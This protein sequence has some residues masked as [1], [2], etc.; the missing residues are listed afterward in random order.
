[1]RTFAADLFLG[2]YHHLICFFSCSHSSL[3]PASPY[4]ESPRLPRDFPATPALQSHGPKA[5][6]VLFFLPPPPH[7]FSPCPHSSLNPAPPLRLVLLTFL[8]RSKI[9]SGPEK[10]EVQGDSTLS[11]ITRRTWRAALGL[12][13]PA[14]RS[15]SGAPRGMNWTFNSLLVPLRLKFAF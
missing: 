7:L 6:F 9:S 5:F 12:L 8:R 15:L 3:N 2:G 1:M 10:P 4:G 11:S 13:A 14:G